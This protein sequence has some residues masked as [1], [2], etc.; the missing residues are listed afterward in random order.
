MKQK[1][2]EGLM[3][4][5]ANLLG[6]IIKNEENNIQSNQPGSVSSSLFTINEGKT[7]N[8]LNFPPSF[9]SAGNSLH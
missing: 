9:N 5:M 3:K 7:Y 8:N 6:K 1:N 4:T 2:K